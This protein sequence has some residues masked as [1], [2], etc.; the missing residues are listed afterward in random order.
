MQHQLLSL[1]VTRAGRGRAHDHPPPIALTFSLHPLLLCAPKA[2][3]YKLLKLLIAPTPYST[4]KAVSTWQQ[5]NSYM[6]FSNKLH[7]NYVNSTTNNNKE[8]V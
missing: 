5:P 1:R 4:T 3:K 8:K 6:L 2:R 7:C